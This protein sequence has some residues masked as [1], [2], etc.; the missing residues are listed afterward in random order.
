M[1]NVL[2][3]DETRF[4]SSQPVYQ[5]GRIESGLCIGITGFFHISTETGAPANPNS[6]FCTSSH[7]L[8]L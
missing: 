2:L 8:V 7:T 3:T 4:F 1:E 5:K 6:E